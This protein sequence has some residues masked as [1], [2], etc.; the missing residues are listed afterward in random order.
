MAGNYNAALRKS[1]DTN[2]DFIAAVTDL[3]ASACRCFNETVKDSEDVYY[4]SMG[5]KLNKAAVS[6]SILPTGW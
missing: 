5:S 6:R 1:G 2:P 4:Q 3:T